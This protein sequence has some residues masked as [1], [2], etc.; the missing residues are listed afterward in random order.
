[1]KTKK[2]TIEVPVFTDK[3]ARTV[4]WRSQCIQCG[5]I[6]ACE[7]GLNLAC[8]KCS[9]PCIVWPCSDEPD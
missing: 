5:H 2:I 6:S 9:S 8:A 1:M 3:S 7:A 4:L